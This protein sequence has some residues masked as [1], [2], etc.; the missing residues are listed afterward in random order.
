MNLATGV[1]SNDRYGG[2]DQIN[3]TGTDGRIEI[4]GS[5]FA[6]LIIGSDRDERFILQGGNDTLDGGGGYDVL[7]YDRNGLDRGIDANLETGII[8]G[9]W[10]GQE[11]RHQVSNIEEVRGSSF[12]DRMVAANTGSRLEGRDGDDILIGGA[13]TDRL[14]GGAGNDYINPGD[15][16]D[17]DAIDTGTGFDTVDFVDA[18]NGFFSLE[19]WSIRSLTGIDVTIYSQSNLGTVSKGSFGQT[20]LSDVRNALGADGLGIAGTDLA[21]T[22]D[23][24]LVQGDYIQLQAGRGAD[25]YTINGTG[26]ARLLFDRDGD[27]QPATQGLVIN[28][29][30]GTVSNDGFGF[31]DSLDIGPDVRLQVLGTMLADDITGSARDDFFLPLAGNDTIRGTEVSIPSATT[32]RRPGRCGSIWLR[33]RH[34]AAMMARPSPIRLLTSGV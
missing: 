16:A 2:R 25:S 1:V 15:N 32:G 27:W 20:T 30:N 8:T 34:R 3:V 28:L 10:F 5:N 23:I 18:Q 22:F 4:Q 26:T 12:G 14:Y 7:R 21:D 11:F 17:F 9:R 24:T 29:A 33:A 31:Q 6:D 19:H 13:G